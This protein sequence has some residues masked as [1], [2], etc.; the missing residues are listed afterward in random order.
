MNVEFEIGASFRSTD[1]YDLGSVLSELEDSGIS[2]LHLD[3]FDGI[4]V[5]ELGLSPEECLSIRS[6][7]KLPIEAHLMEIKPRSMAFYRELGIDRVIIHHESI[8]DKEEMLLAAKED[9]MEVGIALN[10]STPHNDVSFLWPNI[11]DLVL[12][13]GTKSGS[14]GNTYDEQTPNRIGQVASVYTGLI[15][16]NSGLVTLQTQMPENSTLYQTYLAGARRF[17][18]ERGIFNIGLSISKAV[19]LNIEVLERAQSK[20]VE[21]ASFNRLV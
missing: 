9:S 8:G 2:F 21:S 11:V 14:G 3:F 20:L 1:K 16:V 19:Q 6:L 12:V 4:M 18:L 5:R 17:S 13:M 7:S 15:E 10:P